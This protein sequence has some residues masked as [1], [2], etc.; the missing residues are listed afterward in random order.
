MDTAIAIQE[1]KESG[2]EVFQTRW[3]G[4]DISANP[5]VRDAGFLAMEQLGRDG[6]EAGMVS[7]TDV[8][9]RDG[10]QQHI[11]ALSN[12]EL[13]E[14]F[15]LIADTGVDRIEIGH[16]GNGNGDQALARAIVGHIADNDDDE[17]YEGLQ[18]QA[19]FGS[20]PDRMEEGLAILR[21][22][23]QENYPETWKKEMSERMIIQ[24]QD[25]VDENLSNTASEP[26][27]MESAAYRVQTALTMAQHVGF[28]HFSIGGEGSVA[29]PVEEMVQYFRTLTSGLLDRGAESVNVNLFNT[30]GYSAHRDWNVGTLAAFN[31]GVKHDFEGKVTTSVHTH[32]DVSSASSF[33]L[34]AVVAGF[35]RV[36]GT[37][38]MGER[39]GNQPLIEFLARVAEHARHQQ[40]KAEGSRQENESSFAA[41]SGRIA[42]SRVIRI[43]PKVVANLS[44][45][46]SNN[47]E[48][49]RRFGPHAIGKFHATS[50]GSPY[51]Q[52]NGSGPHD[53]VMAA[54]ITDPYKFPADKTYQWTLAIHGAL[55][56][57]TEAMAIGEPDVIDAHT[58]GNH[59]GGG[60]TAAIKE[61]RIKRADTYTI[62][63]ARDAYRGRKQDLADRLLNGVEVMAG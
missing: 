21:E 47:E 18:L 11:N 48:I 59:A 41:H 38:S 56:K 20:Q 12:E 15:D 14:I 19:F 39:R 57:N 7:L 27:D 33:S 60:K 52:E 16:L 61:G 32:D 17:R 35:D 26:Y 3:E 46:Y 40:I 24:V 63:L 28:K 50:V 30:Y 37:N 6:L 29:R 8:T 53:Q 10:L 13:V 49:A 25:R 4:H 31:A 62:E 54:A 5:A 44:N 23:F 51:A 55:G 2:F 22:A 43:A 34:A 1:E 9:L 45:W 58:V 36:E 42:V